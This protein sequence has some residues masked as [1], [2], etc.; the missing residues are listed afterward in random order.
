PHE[1]RN[2][3]GRNHEGTKKNEDHEEKLSCT[4]NSSC[5]SCLFVS[6]WFRLLVSSWFRRVTPPRD[7]IVVGGGVNGLV[8]ATLLAKAG[9]KPLVLERGDRPGGCARTT[10]IAP[11]FRCS[12]L[13]HAAALRPTPVP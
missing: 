3:E 7:V 4:R 6:S 9:R 2:H 8:A 1:S 10:E 5:A 11:G 13:A 12:T